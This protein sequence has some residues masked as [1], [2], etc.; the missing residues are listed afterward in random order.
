MDEQFCGGALGMGR[1]SCIFIG[2]GGCTMNF[3]DDDDDVYDHDFFSV[4]SRSCVKSACL[5]CMCVLLVVVLLTALKSYG[6]T[7]SQ[8]QSRMYSCRL[9]NS[10][11]HI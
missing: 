1:G 11:R 5:V 6:A 7:Q 8:N 3:D 4:G 10:I 2:M 9:T